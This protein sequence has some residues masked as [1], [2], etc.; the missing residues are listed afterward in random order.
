MVQKPRHII[1]QTHTLKKK[2]FKFAGKKR[3]YLRGAE[4]KTEKKKNTY[5]RS[6]RVNCEGRVK[7]ETEQWI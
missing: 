5:R 4:K 6:S 2:S 3:F 1:T 7:E